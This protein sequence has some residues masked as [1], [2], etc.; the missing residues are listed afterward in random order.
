MYL[1]LPF[2][3]SHLTHRMSQ[4]FIAIA[5]Y[6]IFSPDM[7]GRFIVLYKFKLQFH[8][9]GP[10][11]CITRGRQRFKTGKGRRS[12]F[13]CVHQNKEKSSNGQH[14]Y[15]ED[16]SVIDTKWVEFGKMAS[17]SSQQQAYLWSS[18]SY[19]QSTEQWW[20]GGTSEPREIVSY[21]FQWGW[22]AQCAKCNKSRSR[23]L[24]SCKSSQPSGPQ[25]GPKQLSRPQGQ[26]NNANYMCRGGG[27]E[28]ALAYISRVPLV[29]ELE[30]QMIKLKGNPRPYNL[31]LSTLSFEQSLS[32][33]NY[34]LYLDSS[35]I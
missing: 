8:I 33:V 11:Q 35:N 30:E 15:L 21:S 1:P 16:P 23:V 31:A 27:I 4:T 18:V 25:I 17:F 28:E 9:Q 22:S 24:I 32:N 12:Y 20:V 29:F 26:R 13:I 3:A 2:F 6:H 19:F 10:A 7:H 5:R 14:I 34:V